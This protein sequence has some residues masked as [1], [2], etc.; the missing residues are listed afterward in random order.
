ML[1]SKMTDFLA[2]LSW[3]PA[4]A[5]IGSALLR[6]EYKSCQVGA[7]RIGGRK[8]AVSHCKQDRTSSPRKS[9]IDCNVN[10]PISRN[11]G[12]AG[13]LIVFQALIVNLGSQLRGAILGGA[14]TRLPPLVIY[15]TRL[16]DPQ[17]FPWLSAD[18]IGSGTLVRRRIRL[19]SESSNRLLQDR[20]S[21]FIMRVVL[22]T[23]PKTPRGLAPHKNRHRLA[24]KCTRVGRAW[25][26]PTVDE[27]PGTTLRFQD[28]I[29]ESAF[30]L[31][32]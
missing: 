17:G 3:R 19:R 2:H 21:R 24:G 30:E 32:S 15:R 10:R 14:F 23:S 16:I 4:F 31:R 27:I 22:R 28:R 12:Q 25:R 9:K 13:D 20:R 1:G 5:F 6:F 8:L 18:W 7:R 26:I 29:W 11:R